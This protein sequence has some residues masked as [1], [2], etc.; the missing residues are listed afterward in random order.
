[1]KKLFKDLDISKATEKELFSAWMRIHDFPR[2]YVQLKEGIREE[3]LDRGYGQ[4]KGNQGEH[5]A[6][7]KRPDGVWKR[8][9]NIK[10]S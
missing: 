10:L 6:Q 9:T 3:L 5:F 8:D 7:W 4:W 2:G 1:M